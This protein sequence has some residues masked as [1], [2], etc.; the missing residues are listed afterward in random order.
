MLYDLEGVCGRLVLAGRLAFGEACD[1]EIVVAA[2]II[3]ATDADL[4]VT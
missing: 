4:V 3:C 1:A 2:G